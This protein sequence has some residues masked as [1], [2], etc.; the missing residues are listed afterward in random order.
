[1][2]IRNNRRIAT[3]NSL[4]AVTEKKLAKEESNHNNL[5]GSHVERK[6]RL[7]FKRFFTLISFQVVAIQYGTYVFLSWDVMEPITC[8][9]GI[10][11]AIL[12]YGYWLYVNS[13]YSYETLATRKKDK[14]EQTK[15][16]K[17]VIDDTDIFARKDVLDYLYR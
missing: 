8:L 13:S 12:A 15:Y 14:L 4:I 7:F 16:Y 17:S 3:L 6:M 1:M 9:L 2:S 11:D 5:Q 10:S